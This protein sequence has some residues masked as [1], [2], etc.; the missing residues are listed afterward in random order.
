MI[1]SIDDDTFEAIFM[2]YIVTPSYAPFTLTLLIESQAVLSQSIPART[3]GFFKQRSEAPIYKGGEVAFR[4][5]DLLIQI[6]A[7]VV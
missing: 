1:N 4:D 7:G 6:E 3:T 5:R 2:T